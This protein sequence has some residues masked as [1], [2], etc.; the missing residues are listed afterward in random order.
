MPY[1][2]LTIAQLGLATE[3]ETQ[4]MEIVTSEINC[5]Q[6]CTPLHRAY[7]TSDC[8]RVIKNTVVNR[9]KG[10]VCLQETRLTPVEG[11]DY[12][13]YS[14]CPMWACINP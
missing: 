13:A 3:S 5:V 2:A 6:Y 14:G 11:W 12:G 8:C 9:F 4:E 7:C 1:A 10:G